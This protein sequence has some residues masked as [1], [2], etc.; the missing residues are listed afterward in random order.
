MSRWPSLANKSTTY[1]AEYTNLCSELPFLYYRGLCVK[2]LT[3]ME[4]MA[5]VMLPVDTEIAVVFVIIG[6]FFRTVMRQVQA[7]LSAEDKSCRNYASANARRAYAHTHAHT[8]TCTHAHTHTHTPSLSEYQTHQRR[9]SG[10]AR[11]PRPFNDCFS[12]GWL[13]PC[14]SPVTGLWSQAH[15]L[16]HYCHPDKWE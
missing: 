9:Q 12:L 15:L 16:V 7:G 14:L 6:L 1:S 4:I 2:R 3:P 5:F 10:G 8:H 13:G 11:G